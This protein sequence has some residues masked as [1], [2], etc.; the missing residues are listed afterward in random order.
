[1][2]VVAVMATGGHVMSLT[3]P[4]LA[5]QGRQTPSAE[6]S[7]EQA[8]V[9]HAP[10]AASDGLPV[11]LLVAGIVLAF[12]VGL[13]GGH[14]HRRRRLAR[15]EAVLEAPAAEPAVEARPSRRARRSEAEPPEPPEP[16]AAEPPEPVEAAPPEPV[17]AAPP[18]PVATEPPEPFSAESQPVEGAPK[19][20]SRRARRREAKPPESPEPVAVEPPEPVSPEPE[21]VEA[22]PEPAPP[23]T[24]E[25][26]PVEA[27]PIP[28]PPEPPTP[29][30]PEPQPVELAPPAPQPEPVPEPP[31]PKAPA[32]RVI[33]PPA[34]PVQPPPEPP[35]RKAPARR[36]AP[37]SPLRLARRP[38]PA[39]AA[40]APLA[41]APEVP[42]PQ[43]EAPPSRIPAPPLGE[44]PEALVASAPEPVPPS[45]EAP[46]PQAPP[47]GPGRRFARVAPW[48]DD[49][50][51]LWTCELDW[52][53]GYR[54]ANF[55]AMAGAPG[56]GKRRPLAE[57]A[58]VRWAL[59]SEPEP[60]TPELALRVRAL[61]EALEAAGWEHI[62]RGPHW[63]EQRFVWRGAGEPQPIAHVGAEPAER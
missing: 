29:V 8:I 48:P 35:R 25:P 59:M 4:A 55:R 32:P 13:S 42:R 16:V 27:A 28:P 62:G 51:E 17:E 7:A 39:P 33:E 5:E 14:L 23:V 54:K 49:A 10:T 41:E 46:E 37:A 22:A 9:S 36:A 30:S 11:P 63:Y 24:P 3:A 56:A 57:S 40:D 43:A 44:A 12:A 1:M 19:P 45:A 21:P 18:E 50:D 26:Q 38:R 34:P 15:R 47:A 60:P 6:S 61:V 52:K 20:H 2:T 53:A 31:A 58:P